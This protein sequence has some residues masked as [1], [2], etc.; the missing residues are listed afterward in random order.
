M[1]PA[2]FGASCL[3]PSEYLVRSSPVLSPA[4]GEREGLVHWLIAVLVR[5]SA[6]FLG[7]WARPLLHSLSMR[8]VVEFLSSRVWPWRRRGATPYTLASDGVPPLQ[9]LMGLCPPVLVARLLPSFSS[10]VAQWEEIKN[11]R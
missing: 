11:F 7:V 8:R 3:P 2:W 4:S 5:R 1:P 10:R 9:I 6:V